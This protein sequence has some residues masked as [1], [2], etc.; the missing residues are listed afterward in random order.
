MQKNKKMRKNKKLLDS[1]K[2]IRAHSAEVDLGPCRE[3]VE[4]INK[5]RLE[6][7]KDFELKKL[8]LDLRQRARSGT[9]P[10]ALLT[11]AFAL[12]REASERVLGMRHFD[13]QVL[14]GIA[15]HHGGLV[16]MQTGEG[17]TL[18]AVLPAYLNAL[19][20][21]GVHVLTFNDYLAQR[22]A[23]WMGPVY[24]FLGLS[25]GHVREGMSTEERK[26]AYGCD[27]TYLTAKEAGFDYLRS[28]LCTEASELVLRPFNY[29]IID[30][31]DSI[32]IDEARIP[33]VIAG[34]M[35]KTHGVEPARIAELVGSLDPQEDYSPDEYERN[36]FL[37]E[38][39]DQPCRKRASMRQ[40]IQ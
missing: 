10:E 26:K 3:L 28:F 35:E 11:E 2:N 7:L 32:L 16:E 27:I 13:V 19:A 39:G 5:I 15:M 25:A 1:L 37:T 18:A 17:K 29:A 33:L 23:A 6:A 38:K 34:K 40:F 14:A 4:S 36:V 8:S 31:A 12:A 22:D 9:A 20:G 30:E 24:E 21:K